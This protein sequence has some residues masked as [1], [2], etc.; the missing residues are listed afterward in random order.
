MNTLYE[1]TRSSQI[2][3]TASKAVLKGLAPDGGLFVMRDLDE[4][5][6]DI[7]ELS[8]LSYIEMAKKTERYIAL[9]KIVPS[10][11]KG[12]KRLD[13]AK[14]LKKSADFMLNKLHIR[15]DKEVEKETEEIEKEADAPEM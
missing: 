15:L 1:S 4:C 11:V 8:K 7:A 9:K 6:I 10:T 5:K 3:T 12:E 14:D 13:V 2:Q